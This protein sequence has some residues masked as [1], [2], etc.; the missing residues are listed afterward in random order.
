[1]NFGVS[2]INTTK[3][4]I[5]NIVKTQVDLIDT[6]VVTDVEAS[7]MKILSSNVID[8][9]GC[10]LTSGIDIKQS[11][12][13]ILQN[14]QIS[15]SGST[16]TLYGGALNI[17]NSNSTMRNMTFDYNIAKTGG[18]IH[19]SCDTYGIC[20]NIISDSTF[21]NNIAVKQGGAI[22]YDFRRP[23]LSNLTFINNQAAYGPNIAS[24][25]VR[26]V[27]SVMI[28]EPIVLT[29]VTSGMT[30]HQTIRMLLVDYDSQT[31]NLVSNSQI[32]IVPVTSG[33]KL[34]GV[35]YSVLINGQADFDNLQ[36]V[37]G[38]GQDNIEYVA[39]CDLIDSN[40]VSYLSLPTNNSIDVSFRYCQPGE[41]V[42]NNQTCSE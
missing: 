4:H 22:N 9:N 23:E 12:I 10:N 39:T 20:Q 6:V 3:Q 29:N 27:N 14:T 37:Y 36:F 1:M 33:A 31:M 16:N 26:I 24:Y 42:I 18:A 15:S 11:S 8:I 38:P 25:P 32:N 5:I 7:T 30:Y 28:D 17:Q 41:V 2:T 19:I 21:S 13:G 35:D 40:K 34:Q